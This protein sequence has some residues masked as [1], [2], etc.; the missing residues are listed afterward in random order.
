MECCQRSESDSYCLHQNERQ[1]QTSIGSL[2]GV[3][4]GAHISIGIASCV[5]DSFLSLLQ[6]F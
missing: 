3:N 2:V 6:H 5:Q 4:T 1:R